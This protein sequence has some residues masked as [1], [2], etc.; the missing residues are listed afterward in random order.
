MRIPETLVRADRD[1]RMICV[2]TG[3]TPIVLYDLD[4]DPNTITVKTDKFYAF[5]LV[6]RDP[7]KPENNAGQATKTTGTGKTK[8]K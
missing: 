8:K 1:F 6:F 2:T 7:V 5:A 4:T 3:G